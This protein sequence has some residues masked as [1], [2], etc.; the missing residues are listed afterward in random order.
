MTEMCETVY[1]MLV[2]ELIRKAKDAVKWQLIL[3]MPRP[4]QAC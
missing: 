3:K 2:V 4:T 1:H